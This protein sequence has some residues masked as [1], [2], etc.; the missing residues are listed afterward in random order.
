MEHLEPTE[1]NNSYVEYQLG[2]QFKTRGKHPRV[3]TVVDMWKTYNAQG[4]LV[5]VRYV[6]TYELMG[7]VVTDYDVPA[8]TIAMGIIND[9]AY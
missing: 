5:R 6:A 4:E 8:T 2:T 3:M 1:D 9:K 7:Q